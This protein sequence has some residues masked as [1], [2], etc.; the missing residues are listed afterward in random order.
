VEKIREFK[1]PEGKKAVRAFLGLVNSLRRVI[2]LEVIRQM[3]ILTPL[4]SSK[5]ELKPTPAQRKAFEDI[6]E[7]LLREPLYGNLIN[8]K[9][10]KFLFVDA[11]SSTG[12][13]GAVLMQKITGTEDK[14]VPE[15]LDL[16]NEVHRIIFD[17]GLPYEPV[18]LVTKLPVGKPKITLPKTVP[19]SI[20]KEERLLGFS[21]VNVRDSFFWSTISIIAIYNGPLPSSVMEYRLQAAKKLKSGVL[22]NKLKD[23]TFN[24]NYND[25]R[26]FMDDFVKG[27]AGL[28]LEFFLAEALAQC[29][30]RPMVIISTLDRHKD[31]PIKKFNRESTKPPLIY[32]VV[33]RDGH[34]I[35]IPFFYNKNTV[36][37]LDQLKGKVQIISYSA[38]TVLEALK[39]RPILD[40][41]SYAVVVSLHSLQRFVSGV[42]VTL[43]TDSRVLFYLFSSTVHNSSVKIKR[44]C[45][46]IIY[47]FPYVVLRFVRTTENLA[48]FLTRQGMPAGDLGRVN[49]KEISV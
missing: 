30:Y 41:E 47:D 28:D 23:F 2:N 35:F 17:K 29:L 46:K 12:V 21:D 6:K 43:L 33:K 40:L 31:K 7:M 10:E 49:I 8:E 3:G 19:P 25:Y 16:D 14:V 15:Y 9:A 4:T 32:G 5:A 36:L 18:N 20:L 37:R 45:L 38:K 13:L 34:K 24:L 44:W 27:E 26:K 42:K 1:F 48:D 22:N 39:T 11:A